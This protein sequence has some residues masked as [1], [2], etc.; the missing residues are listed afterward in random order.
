LLRLPDSQWCYA[1]V[2]EIP[3]APVL[4]H[5]ANDGL[6]FGSFN[7]ASKVCDRCIDLWCRVLLSAPGSQLRMFAVP[8]GRATAA[9]RQR[10]ERRGIERRRVAFAPRQ[11]IDDY[12]AAIAGVDVALDTFPY[13]GGTTSFDVLWTGVPL[14]ALAGERPVSRSGISILSNLQLPE[15]I[16]GTD[17]AYVETNLR[18]A[19]DGQWRRALRESL[20]ETMRRSPLMDAARFTR[21]FESGIRRMLDDVRP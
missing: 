14:V 6:V 21:N 13:G 19:A 11:N 10:F 12:F 18:L 2:L 4:R 9:L 20:R 8:P 3:R 16:A 1:P 5:G 7:H 15:L 17:D